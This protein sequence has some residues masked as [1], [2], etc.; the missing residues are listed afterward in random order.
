MTSISGVRIVGK[1]NKWNKAR[2]STICQLE[3]PSLEVVRVAEHP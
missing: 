1:E 2:R 3:L